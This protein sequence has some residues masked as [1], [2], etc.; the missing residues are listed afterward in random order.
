MLPQ[1]LSLSASSSSAAPK[2]DVGDDVRVM[3]CVVVRMKGC[4]QPILLG[5][6]VKAG[7]EKPKLGKN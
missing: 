3:G 6:V 1:P 7:R 2:R 5:V 4:D